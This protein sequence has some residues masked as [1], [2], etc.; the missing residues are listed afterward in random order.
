MSN[1]RLLIVDDELSVR[2]STAVADRAGFDVVQASNGA[3]ALGNIEGGGFDAVLNDM[4]S[5]RDRR[6]FFCIVCGHAPQA[7]GDLHA[8]F[9]R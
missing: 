4:A 2:T 6:P 9:A 1:G 7:A 5:T 3:D 8:Q